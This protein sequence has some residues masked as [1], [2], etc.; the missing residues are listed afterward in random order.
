MNLNV[1][2]VVIREGKEPV[3]SK[4]IC[5]FIHISV[6]KGEFGTYSRFFIQAG[7]LRI[8]PVNQGVFRIQ[9]NSQLKIK[10]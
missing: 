4:K 10:Y 8:L 5:D 6:Q 2:L 9:H 7:E 3:Y 1:F